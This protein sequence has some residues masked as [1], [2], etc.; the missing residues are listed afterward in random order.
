MRSLTRLTV[1]SLVFA[2]C[3]LVSDEA[4]ADGYVI[5]GGTIFTSGQ[6]SGVL[7][8]VNLSGPGI[9]VTGLREGTILAACGPCTS[10]NILS[11]N[12]GFSNGGATV[13]LDGTTYSNVYLGG[14]FNIT[15]PNFNLPPAL[16]ED[17]IITMPFEMSG[18]MIG[19]RGF[20]NPVELFR[21]T[22]TGQGIAT[23]TF[24]HIFTP[25]FPNPNLYYFRNVTYNFQPAPVPEPA[26]LLLLC[27]GLAGVA[28]RVRKRRRVSK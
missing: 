2:F 21:T 1:A 6:G 18:N 9:S 4:R 19:E 5:T 8:P 11:T 13:T 7:S 27:T 15:G 16:N 20:Q 10:H 12:A 22:V 23:F 28:A 24:R 25:G 17:V 3:C 14:N 26:T